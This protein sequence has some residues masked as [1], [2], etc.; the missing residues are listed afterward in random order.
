M[1]RLT[2][3]GGNRLSKFEPSLTRTAAKDSTNPLAAREQCPGC[4]GGQPV[5][6]SW[7]NGGRGFPVSLLPVLKVHFGGSAFCSLVL[8]STVNVVHCLLLVAKVERHGADWKMA[9]L[10][11]AS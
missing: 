1:A 2:L 6:G 11:C 8:S 10:T 9:F 3:Y 5:L 4:T 7:E